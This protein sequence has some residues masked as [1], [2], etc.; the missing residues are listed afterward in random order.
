MPSYSYKVESLL[1]ALDAI[2][3]NPKLSLLHV[4]CNSSAQ[5]I[6]TLP[7]LVAENLPI[8]VAQDF[9]PGINQLN[10][11]GKKILIMRG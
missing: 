3:D 5:R 2:L 10:L 1:Y 6:R 4:E 8:F 7:G 11:D 9:Q